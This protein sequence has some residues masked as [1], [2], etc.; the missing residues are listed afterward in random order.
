M[1]ERL[2]KQEGINIMKG[3]VG[4]EWVEWGHVAAENI[5]EHRKMLRKKFYVTVFPP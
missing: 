5:G 2:Q 3:Q 1:A 4:V